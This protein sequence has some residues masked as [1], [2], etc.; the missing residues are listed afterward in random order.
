MMR[1]ADSKND[2]GK[3]IESA[4][5]TNDQNTVYLKEDFNFNSGKDE[6]TF[7]YSLDRKTWAQL[8]DTLKMEYTMPHFMGYRFALCNYSTKSIGGYVDFDYFRV[9]NE[10]NGT[11]PA[12]S[13]LAANLGSVKSIVGVKNMTFDMP[14]TMDNLPGGK[15]TSINASLNIPDDLT[16]S[17]VKFNSSNVTGSVNF[18]F[19]NNQLVLSVSDDNV[20]FKD[21]NKTKVFATIKFKVNNYVAQT[22]TKTIKIDYIEA[23]NN[24]SPVNYNVNKAVSSVELTYL[25]TGAVAKKLGYSNPLMDYKYGADPWA[26]VYNGRV[27]VYMSSDSLEYDGNNKIVDNN[28]SNIKSISV[29]LQ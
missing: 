24:T 17:D 3:I 4:D 15:Y 19:S 1:N 5:I 12:T 29:I 6:A 28:Y 18:A 14:I 13:N 16:V 9:N 23:L 7:Y 22:T 11:T 20:D 26:L 2:S 21:T 8:G 27:Y 10:I 25:D